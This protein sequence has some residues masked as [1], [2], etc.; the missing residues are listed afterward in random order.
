MKLRK[1]S[2]LFSLLHTSPVQNIELSRA[3]ERQVSLEVKRDDLLHPII[4][5]NKWR[6]L[7]YLLLSIEKQGY[8]R[9]AT[10]GGRYSNFIHTL[11]YVCYLLDWQCDLFIRAFP[12]Q[13]ETAT[14]LDCKKWG[15]NIHYVDR[16]NYRELRKQPPV[17]AD[18]VYWIAE[19]GMHTQSILGIKET[20]MELNHQYDYIVIATATGTS[21]AGLIEGAVIYQPKAKILGIC[22][23]NNAEQQRQDIINLVQDDRDNWSVVEGY[24][25]GGFAKSDITLESFITDF[26]AQQDIP[27]EPVYSGKS[28]YAVNDLVNKGY[29]FK[30]AS[31]LLIH[32]GGLQGTRP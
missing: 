13:A 7:K 31:I 16:K 8:C 15:A 24:E 10:M 22:V 12:Q 11:S 29:F 14:L 18:E 30:N 32:C 3:I 9:V 17:L 1:V 2:H 21:V 20:M 5:G 28:F 19:G 23:L 25:F 4:S 6:K 26:D 27:L